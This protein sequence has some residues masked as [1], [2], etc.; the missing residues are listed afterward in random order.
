MAS[1]LGLFSQGTCRGGAAGEGLRFLLS[2]ELDGW[3]FAWCGWVGGFIMF[4]LEAVG[5]LS[6]RRSLIKE[7]LAK[8]C[9]FLCELL[10]LSEI[11]RS[12]LVRPLWLAQVRLHI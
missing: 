2:K 3:M 4:Y 10:R 12:L 5:G 8:N 6:A 1:S 11:M 7:I 9:Q